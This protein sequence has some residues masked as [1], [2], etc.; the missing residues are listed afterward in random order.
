MRVGP[1]HRRRRQPWR[2]GSL[3][4]AGRGTNC[5]RFMCRCRAG[6]HP[7]N[8]DVPHRRANASSSDGAGTTVSCGAT[9]VLANAGY[10]VYHQAERQQRHRQCVCAGYAARGAFLD[11]SLVDHLDHV[12]FCKAEEICDVGR[13]APPRAGG[14]PLYLYVALEYAAASAYLVGLTTAGRS[15]ALFGHCGSLL[16]S[17][18]CNAHPFR[19]GP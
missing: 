8:V 3:T 4:I 9:L 19:R 16:R 13:G 10:A 1:L 11:P 5:C 12:C 18:P 15:P 6:H 2:L 14:Q 17:T 7:S